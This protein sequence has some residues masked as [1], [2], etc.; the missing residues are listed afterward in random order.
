MEKNLSRFKVGIYSYSVNKMNNCPNFSVCGKTMRPELKV[1]TSCFW[2][3]K[4]T[5]L[6]FFDDTCQICSQHGECVRY[7][8][9][10]HYVCIKCHK[11]HSKCPLCKIKTC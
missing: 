10:E 6:D 7:R 4:N 3:Y 8:K 2:K 9:C 11:L 1:C 5:V